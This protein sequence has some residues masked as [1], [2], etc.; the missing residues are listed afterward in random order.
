MT[1]TV[2]NTEISTLGQPFSWYGGEMALAVDGDTAGFRLV[3]QAPTAAG[4]GAPFSWQT[5]NEIDGR[6]LVYNRGEYRLALIPIADGAPGRV[7]VTL[8]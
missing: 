4:P 8:R 2:L 7:K 6:A 5:L 3:I 1:T